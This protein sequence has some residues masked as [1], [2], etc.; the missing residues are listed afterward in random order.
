M[1][2]NHS[3][4]DGNDAEGRSRDCGGAWVVDNHG[5]RVGVGGGAVIEA[6]LTA[7]A[8]APA[9]AAVAEQTCCADVGVVI[10]QLSSV[11]IRV[12][13]EVKLVTVST[14]A[15]TTRSDLSPLTFVPVLGL[16]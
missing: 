12:M 13:D 1:L 11:G 14:S 4:D 8:P 10:H 5:S 3:D 9:L 2:T 16:N 7:P 6:A 15:G